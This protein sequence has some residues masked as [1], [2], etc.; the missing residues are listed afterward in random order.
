MLFISAI[1]ISKMISFVRVGLFI[2]Q[3]FLMKCPLI[4]VFFPHLVSVNHSHP[5][6]EFLYPADEEKRLEEQKAQTVD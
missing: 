5:L 6:K 4:C 2:L 3:Y 1:F